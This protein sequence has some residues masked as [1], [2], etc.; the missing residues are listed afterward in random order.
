ML[1]MVQTADHHTVCVFDQAN[2]NVI[3]LGYNDGSFRK[4]IAQIF[5]THSYLAVEADPKYKSA[6]DIKIVNKLIAASSG[7]NRRFQIEPHG[8][9]SS[10]AVLLNQ[11]ATDTLMVQTISIKD[12]YSAAPFSITDILKID[13][14]GSEF[15]ALD[16]NTIKFLATNTRQICIEFHDWLYPEFSDRRDSILR[17]FVDE[18]FHCIKMSITNHGAYLLLNKNTSNFNWLWII[19]GWFGRYFFALTRFVQKLKKFAKC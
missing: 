19:R 10:T 9:G 6:S 13:I 17:H 1:K 11:D 3:D 12:V 18:G 5:K 8:K 16:R 15:E 4:D 2:A 7:E 14:E